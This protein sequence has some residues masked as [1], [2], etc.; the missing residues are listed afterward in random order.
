MGRAVRELQ[1][2]EL[3]GRPIFVREDRE[4]GGNNRGRGNRGNNNF[5]G[6]NNRG[7]RRDNN[8][9]G[10]DSGFVNRGDRGDRGDRDDRGDS[11]GYAKRGGEGA[12]SGSQL[13]VGNLS[14]DT[15]WRELKDHFRQCGDVERTEVMETPDGRRKGFGT[16]RFTSDKDAQ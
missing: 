13:F 3:N 15:T 16:V 1:N 12:S 6:N 9:R 11:A 4:S 8:N 2:S 5:G 10:G 14:Y 7:G